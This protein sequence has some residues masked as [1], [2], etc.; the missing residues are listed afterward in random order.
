MTLYVEADD[1]FE[2]WLMA[3]SFERMRDDF[4]AIVGRI[5]TMARR[6]VRGVA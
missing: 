1:I 4:A 6:A 5:S 3:V 2:A